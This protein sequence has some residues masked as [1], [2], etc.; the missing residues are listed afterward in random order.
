MN[1][2]YMD[3]DHK[4]HSAQTHGIE[5]TLRKT[6]LVMVVQNEVGHGFVV[7]KTLDC[8]K[9]LDLDLGTLD[10]KHFSQRNRVYKDEYFSLVN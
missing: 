8:Y 10:Q 3:R 9:H 6:S 4:A 7:L 1:C 5:V 2:C